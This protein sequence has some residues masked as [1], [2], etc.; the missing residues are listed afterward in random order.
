[1]ADI[2]RYE[3]EM[4]GLS[5]TSWILFVMEQVL[6]RWWD[7]SPGCVAVHGAYR[8]TVIRILRDCAEFELNWKVATNLKGDMVWLQIF[9]DSLERQNYDIKRSGSGRV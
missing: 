7:S 1:M 5:L 8:K 3:D 6:S 4:I 2:V 9:G